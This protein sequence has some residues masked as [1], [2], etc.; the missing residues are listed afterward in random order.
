MMKDLRSEFI[1]YI[2]CICISKNEYGI[3]IKKLTLII[4]IKKR[5][6]IESKLRVG[7]QRQALFRKSA[8]V[9]SRFKS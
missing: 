4:L 1:I 3:G 5:H 6:L 2:T 9:R 7:R 8:L